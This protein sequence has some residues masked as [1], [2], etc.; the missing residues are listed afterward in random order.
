MDNSFSNPENRM[1]CA[2]LKWG[3]ICQFFMNISD[4]QLHEDRLKN[5]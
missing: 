4:D 5:W 1:V 3:K 2:H